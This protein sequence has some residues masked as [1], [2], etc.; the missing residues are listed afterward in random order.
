VRMPPSARA[1]GTRR[2]MRPK[3]SR[4]ERL[5]ASR[6][7]RSARALPGRRRAASVGRDHVAGQ[8]PEQRERVSATSTTW[9]RGRCNAEPAVRGRVTSTLSTRSRAPDQRR[10]GAAVDQQRPF[11]GRAERTTRAYRRRHSEATQIGPV[12]ARPRP[13]LRR[14]A[15]PGLGDRLA[16][17]QRAGSLRQRGQQQRVELP[18]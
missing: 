4:R 3:P 1:G 16:T 2:Q 8:R 7:P 11:D 10:L 9:P 13:G 12:A 18:R 5:V 14:S 15:S 6:L 17:T